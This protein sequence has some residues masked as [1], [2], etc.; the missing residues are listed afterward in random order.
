VNFYKHHLGDYAAATMHLSWDEDCAYRRL[1]DQYYK[2]EAPIPA[3]LNE[4]CRLA[5]A[6]NSSQKKAVQVVLKEFFALQEDGWHQ[7][8]CDEEVAA[9]VESGDEREARL[10]NERER[11][12]RHREERKD[13]FSKLREMDVSPPYDTKTETLRELLVT[14]LSQDLSRVTAADVSQPVT[15]T[16]TAIQTPEA[17][18][19]KPDTSKR[20]EEEARASRLPTD[21]GLTDSRKAIAESERLDPVRTHQKFT[22]HWRAASGANAR[23]RDWEAAWRNWCRNEADRKTA[24]KVNGSNAHREELGKFD[25]IMARSH[26]QQTFNADGKPVDENGNVIPF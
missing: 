13:L 22:D 19:H 25:R 14:H 6:T 17:I 5:R 16:A 20:Q 2:R 7:K 12:R 11:Q 21:W 15:R 8:R 3:D 10:E 9:A 1:L 23:K 24:P 18:S 26:A 4:A